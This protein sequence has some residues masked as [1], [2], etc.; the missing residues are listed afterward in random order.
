MINSKANMRNAPQ[1]IMTRALT[2]AP[3][4]D[5]QHMHKGVAAACRLG[6]EDHSYR[7]LRNY[8]ELSKSPY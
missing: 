4:Q 3:T 5:S 2:Q 7:Q 6:S 8:I 1:D